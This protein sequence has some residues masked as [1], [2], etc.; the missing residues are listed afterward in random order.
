MLFCWPVCAPHEGRNGVDGKASQALGPAEEETWSP[1]HKAGVAGGLHP[2]ASPTLF[3]MPLSGLCFLGWL[4]EGR[5]EA[6]EQIWAIDW[7][8]YPA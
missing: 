8:V 7:H 4:S 5:R 6:R 2:Q 3:P 1:G